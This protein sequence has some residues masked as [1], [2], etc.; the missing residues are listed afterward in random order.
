MNVRIYCVSD[1]TRTY[2]SEKVGSTRLDMVSVTASHDLPSFEAVRD[3]VL[4][5]LRYPHRQADNLETF[6]WVPTLYMPSERT[7]TSRATGVRFTRFGSWRNG[8]AEADVLSVLYADVDNNDT[9]RPVVT[10]QAVATALDGLGCSYF[11]YTT[12]SHTTEKP[13]FRVIIDTD[14]NLTRQ[15]MLRVVVWLNWNVFGQQADLSVYDPG[16]FVFAPPH[17]A[18]VMERLRAMPLSVDFG[19]AQQARLQE[20]HPG[21]WTAYLKQRQPK[22]DPSTP[23]PE[24]L[25]AIEQRRAD[26]SARPEIGIDNPA[27]FDPAWASFYP[28]RIVNRSYWET[29]RSLLGMVWAK[30]GGSLTYGEMDRILRQIDATADGYF[31]THH[32]EQ[33]AEEL[34]DWIMSLPVEAKMDDWSPILERD[35]TGLVV[36]VKEGEC[37]EGKT[38]DELRR[39]ARERGRYVY[40]VDKIENIEKRRQEFFEIA[41]RV[42]AIRFLTFEA[43]CQHRDLRVALQLFAIRQELDKAPAGRPTIVFVTQAGAMQMDWSRWGD[44]ELVFDE[45]PDTFQLYRIDAKHHSEVLRRYVRP[46]TDDGDCYTL[47]LTNAG[48]DLARTTDVDDYDKV[49]HG[50]CVLLNKPNTH[51]WVKQQAWDNPTEGGVMEFFA[52]TSPLNLAPFTAVRLLGDEAMKSVTVRAWSQKWGVTF[53][54]VEFERRKRLVPTTDRVTIKYVSDHR[55]SSITRFREGDMPLDAWSTWIKEDARNEPVLWSAN[56]RLKAKVKLDLGDHISPKAHGRNDLQHYRR[57]AW[58]V[59]MKASKFEISTLKEVCCLSAHELTEWREYN[60]MFQFVMRSI[61]RDFTSAEP[62]AIYVFSR[63]QAEYLQE[64]LGGR[65]EKVTGIVTDKPSRCL[66]EEGPMTDAERQKV[67]YW[68]RKMVSAGVTDVRLLAKAGK[69]SEREIRLVNATSERGLDAPRRLSKA[70]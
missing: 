14:R 4:N 63:R 48:R 54:P 15:E 16:D 37:G 38:H 55:D 69:L 52:I 6:G 50:L 66:D 11:M 60:V 30:A 8:T 32:G 35:E 9:G 29:M 28:E 7:F 12:F 56:E 19:L 53:Q 59:A 18:T 46:E 34:I 23:S 39:M 36:Q 27:A 42:N 20:E 3:H 22:A 43:H 67:R 25:A 44:H 40:V 51:V 47:G 45:V 31:I 17:A 57:V 10:M 2:I 65:I 62:V 26:K 58:L 13:K 41:G 5:S 33:K 24:R 21:S 1:L 64:R 68:R 61:L 70:A 49:H